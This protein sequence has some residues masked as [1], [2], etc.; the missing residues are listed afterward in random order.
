M[1]LWRLQTIEGS[2]PFGSQLSSEN[3][4]ALV[5]QHA[6]EQQLVPGRRPGTRHLWKNTPSATSSIVSLD[7]NPFL[8]PFTPSLFLKRGAAFVQFYSRFGPYLI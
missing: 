8:G 1:S 6:P 2:S 5:T 7:F 3:I 4:T